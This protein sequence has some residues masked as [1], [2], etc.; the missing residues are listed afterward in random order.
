MGWMFI[1]RTV[2]NSPGSILSTFSGEI[3]RL[4]SRIVSL[5]PRSRLSAFSGETAGDNGNK[6]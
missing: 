1:S 3:G 5:S 6:L 4:I 2:S